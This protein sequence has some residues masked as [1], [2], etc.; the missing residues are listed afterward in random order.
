MG[1]FDWIGMC[2]WNGLQI[3]CL[4]GF[5][6]RA[7]RLKGEFFQFQKQFQISSFDIVVSRTFRV[8]DLV[9]SFQIIS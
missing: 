5:K 6:H 1:H 2:F 9:D 3:E 7:T 8:I 4:G